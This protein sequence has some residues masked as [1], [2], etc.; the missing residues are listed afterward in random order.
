[1]RIA[2]GQF[3]ELSE[4]TLQFAN[5]LG[6]KGVQLNTP[7]LP[8]QHRWEYEDLL[9]LRTQCEKYGLKLEAL[10]NVPIHFYNKIMLGAE[11]RDEQ[12]EHYQATIRNMGRAGIPILGYHFMPNGVWRTSFMTPGRGQARVSSFD[13][14]LVRPGEPGGT[15]GNAVVERNPM[16]KQLIEEGTDRVITESEMWENYKYFIKAVVPVAEESGVK[17]ALH[18]DDPPVEMLGGIARLFRNVENF[19]KAMEIADSDAWGLD[20]CLGCCSEMPEGNQNVKEMIEYFGPRG[21]ILYIHFRDVQ[22]TVPKFQ[23]CFLGEGNYSPA[24]T[25]LLLKKSGFNGFIL[26]DHVPAIVND[27]PWGHRSRAHAIG[28]MQGLLNMIEA[29]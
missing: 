20:L 9:E 13:I 27:S 8:G 1:M 17:L 26:D 22:G 3:N 28:Y 12:I 4:E 29:Q 6:V 2:V 15:V 24:Q 7:K 14:S 16:L 23:E 11:G 25:M 5:Q 10:E 18:P 21:K 19:K